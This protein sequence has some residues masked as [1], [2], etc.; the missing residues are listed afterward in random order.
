[1]PCVLRFG[2]FKVYIY[3]QDTD[4]HHLPHCH[5]L[6]PGSNASVS[7]VTLMAL[8][9]E[10]ARAARDILREHRAELIAEW[11]RLNPSRTMEEED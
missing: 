1:M 5:V 11:N 7:L 6:G 10:L 2:P 4:R 9:G 8:E 3:G